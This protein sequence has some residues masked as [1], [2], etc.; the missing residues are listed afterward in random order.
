MSKEDN[1]KGKSR[2]IPNSSTKT[3]RGSRSVHS[4]KDQ[5]KEDGFKPNYPDKEK[6][7]E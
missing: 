1:N 2:T 7:E 5:S 6:E 4:E 3:A